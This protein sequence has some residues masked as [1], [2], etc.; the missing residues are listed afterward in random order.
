MMERSPNGWHTPVAHGRWPGM[1]ISPDSSVPTHL[2]AY[3]VCRLGPWLLVPDRWNTD[4]ERRAGYLCDATGR[5]SLP[6]SC[7]LLV[8]FVQ[9]LHR[10]GKFGERGDGR[11]AAERS[12]TAPSPTGARPNSGRM[13]CP[14]G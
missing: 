3:P 14:A 9:T 11:A 7:D 4:G 2:T 8:E 1:V 6:N 5:V 13:G 10:V 12:T